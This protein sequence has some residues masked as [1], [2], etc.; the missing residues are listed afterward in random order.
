[1]NR[2]KNTLDR[3]LDRM[4]EYMLPQ[5]MGTA[6][7]LLAL[8]QAA[9]LF[10]TPDR[11]LN[12][13]AA[14]STVTAIAQPFV[15][16]LV[17]G[18]LGLILVFGSV[19]DKDYVRGF[20]VALCGLHATIGLLTIYPIIFSEALPTAFSFYMGNSFMCYVSYLM[21]RARVAKR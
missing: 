2:A 4:S 16:G 18:A 13:S 15:W 8:Y 5:L 12:D 10:L 1:M 9:A 7:G 6:L 20:S 11:F 17:F 14:Y 3:W 19:R 21:W